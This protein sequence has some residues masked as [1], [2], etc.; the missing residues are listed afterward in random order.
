ME[1]EKL[2]PCPDPWCTNTATVNIAPKIVSFP[3]MTEAD[4][5]GNT[6]GYF[7]RCGCGLCGPVSFTKEGAVD[8]WNNRPREDLLSEEIGQL[9]ADKELLNYDLTKAYAEIKRLKIIEEK[10][11]LIP[12]ESLK[13]GYPCPPG[14]LTGIPCEGNDKKCEECWLRWRDSE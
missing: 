11:N 3:F 14:N 4:H 13:N 7:V 10:F 2:K 1:N 9:N 8:S 6:V 12:W 5:S